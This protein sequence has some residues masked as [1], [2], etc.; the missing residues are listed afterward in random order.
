MR[1]LCEGRGGP[2]ALSADGARFFGAVAGWTFV[3]D[4]VV[5]GCGAI[6]PEN[7]APQYVAHG[8]A[9]LGGNE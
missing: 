7:L 4:G 1:Q 8:D 6:V 5:Y 3:R 9:Q 2:V